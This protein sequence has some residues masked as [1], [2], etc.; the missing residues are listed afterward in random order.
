MATHTKKGSRELQN[1]F[2]DPAFFSTIYGNVS[3]Y[4]YYYTLSI[5]AV[6]A[7]GM[8]PVVSSVLDILFSL[9]AR[10]SVTP[11]LA[12]ASLSYRPLQELQ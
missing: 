11:P 10:Y 1:V 2:G 12:T 6:F 4:I 7:A 5:I 8:T 9:P 3:S